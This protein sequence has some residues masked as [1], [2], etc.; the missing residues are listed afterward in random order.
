MLSATLPIATRRDIR[1]AMPDAETMITWYVALTP[2]WWATGTLFFAPYV[3][4]GLIILARGLP[5]SRGAVVLLLAWTAVWAM[6]AVATS[7]VWMES[8]R[9]WVGL[10][11]SVLSVGNLNWIALGLC[12]AIGWERRL[13]TGRIARAACI[14]CL[15]ILVFSGIGAFA[16]LVLG[17]PSL[18]L[19]NLFS[20][21]LP[22]GIL[23][24]FYGSMRFHAVLMGEQAV[25][26]TLFY[27]WPT[28]LS[29]GAALAMM[30]GFRD[31]DW[32]W[33][34]IAVLG[35]VAGVLA[36]ASRTVAA[37]MLVA[38]A[39][40]AFGAA[41]FRSRVL[42]LILAAVALNLAV[43]AG[44]DLQEA[45]ARAY[46]KFTAARPGSSMA[47]SIIYDH[48]WRAILDSP[49]VGHGWGEKTALGRRL[50]AP[51]GSHSTFYGVLYTGG[52]VTFAAVLAAFGT[53]IGAA[54]LRL[55]DKPVT[56]C[57]VLG[58]LFVIGMISFG[59][60]VNFL[61]PTLLLPLFWMGGVLRP[62]VPAPRPLP[63]H[64][65]GLPPVP[66]RAA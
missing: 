33:R 40:V 10:L 55:R 46:D 59:E 58:M 37:G 66:A 62:A 32:R 64:L 57:T 13:D 39:L 8:G 5:Y 27:P 24:S 38:L 65:A 16:N 45:V 15:W 49:I 26:L 56:A 50:I 60:N 61:V 2:L 31:P 30:I 28:A 42:L 4:L 7:I 6:Q 25:R 52:I 54:L 12:L 47:R 51:L 41:S 48:T 19:P 36:G 21:V 11:R 53:V 23:P 14:L 63:L 34:A 18:E 3:C 43:L 1:A 29:L 17:M 35:G 44:F 9:S 20:L 22:K